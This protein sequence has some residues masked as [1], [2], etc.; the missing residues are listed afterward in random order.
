MYYLFCNTCQYTSPDFRTH[1]GLEIELLSSTDNVNELQAK[2][3][4]G[5]FAC[6]E[7]HGEDV[8]VNRPV[9]AKC[10]DCGPV[11]IFATVWNGEAPVSGHCPKCSKLRF[12]PGYYPPEGKL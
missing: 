10:P 3:D 5:I 6:P 7:C 1:N 9:T 12:F 11:K 4:Q 2:M 8:Y